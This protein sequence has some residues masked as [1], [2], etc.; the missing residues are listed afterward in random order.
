MRKRFIHRGFAKHLE[1]FTL[2][3]ISKR[4][5]IFAVAGGDAQ[6]G[7]AKGS[8][9][10]AEA[11]KGSRFWVH[12][13]QR[14]ERVRTFNEDLQRVRIFGHVLAR[15]SKG[16]VLLVRICRGFAF[17]AKVRK[18]FAIFGEGLP[19]VRILGHA[20]AETL[21]GS[22][23]LGKVRDNWQGWIAG[24]R[25]GF[26]H[27]RGSSKGF[28][29]LGTPSPNMQEGSYFLAHICKGFALLRTCWPKP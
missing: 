10:R 13:S 18:G 2:Q 16:F 12:A 23:L 25:Q 3:W 11:P 8:D 21:K 22:P 26:G 7:P 19:R 28:A 1:G 20:L 6:R 5:R 15:V 17:R 27:S 24:P 4:V 14:I 29:L 9:F